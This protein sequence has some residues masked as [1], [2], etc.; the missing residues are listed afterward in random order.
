MSELVSRYAA[1]KLAKSD[2][3]DLAIVAQV[4]LD[5]SREEFASL[6]LHSYDFVSKLTGCNCMSGRINFRVEEHY[7][8]ILSVNLG[9]SAQG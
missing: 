5:V 2:L 7:G 6:A 1:L 4:P 3:G 9:H 8:E